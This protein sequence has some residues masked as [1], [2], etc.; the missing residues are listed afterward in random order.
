[1][2]GWEYPPFISGGL[3]VH[4]LE[5]TVRLAKMGHKID[6]F[7][8]T[9]T[10]PLKSPHENIR[11]IEVAPTTLRPYFSTSKK[12]QLATY[13]E[14]LIRAVD[15][16]AKM[17]VEFVEEEHKKNPYDLI[18]AHDWLTSKGAILCKK[19]LSI[20]LVQTVHSTEFDRTSSPWDLILEIEKPMVVEPDSIIAVSRL[21]GEQ[22][23]KLGAD[24]KKIHV[25]YNGVD[26]SKYKH[27][28][29]HSFSRSIEGKKK[30]LFLGRLTE[31][32]GPVQ[33][34]HSAKK[35]LDKNPNV[36]FLIAG[37]GSMLPLL[38]NLTIGLGISNNVKFLG[39]LSEDEQRKIYSACDVYVMPSTSEPFGIVVL[40]A[41]ASGTP[42]IISK[43]SGVS[44]VVSSALKV[45][46]WDINGMAQKILAVLNYSPLANSM[47]HMAE[48]DV[49]KLTWEKCA[50]ETCGVYE[51][52]VRKWA[53]VKSGVV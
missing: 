2:L 34:L 35:V 45:D 14:D 38:I 25:V 8:P 47:K 44:E 52:A 29:I 13:G 11:L 15:A 7:M 16:Y 23:K 53:Q 18:H 19:K 32:K 49:E 1:M 43:T 50:Q 4:C 28:G 51:Q 20:P 40:E 21:T 12:G 30:V 10:H 48:H 6:F 22:I 42:V 37:K 36:V 5:L 26:A 3:G 31:Q 33:F 17:V 46:F 39:F 27:G 41:M 9:C 24:E